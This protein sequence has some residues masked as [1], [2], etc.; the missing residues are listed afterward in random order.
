[1]KKTVDIF[2]EKVLKDKAKELSNDLPYGKAGLAIYYAIKSDHDKSA[3]RLYNKYINDI[4]A[5]VSESCPMTL[6]NG[7][8]GICLSIDLILKYYKKGNSDYVLGDIDSL[9]Y[10]KFCIDHSSQYQSVDNYIDALYYLSCHLR[11]SLHG[12]ERRLLFIRESMV[13]IDHVYSSLPSNF[14]EE[15]LP[16]NL[17]NKPLLFL[18]SLACFYSQGIY[19]DRI[20]HILNEVAYFPFV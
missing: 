5:H 1:M 10:R 16:V 6:E 7:L 15:P 11:L 13:W 8:L 14:F 19:C 9:I 2:L 17:I 3:Q 4:L 12:K 18:D 20:C